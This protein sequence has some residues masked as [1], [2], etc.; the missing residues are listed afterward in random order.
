MNAWDR[1]QA[2]NRQWYDVMGV[3]TS[4]WYGSVVETTVKMDLRI[5]AS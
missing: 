5:P 3:T 2:T 1:D 4:A